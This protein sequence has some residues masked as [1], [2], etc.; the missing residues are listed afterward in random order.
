MENKLPPWE[1]YFIE[2]ACDQHNEFEYIDEEDVV[3]EVIHHRN[4]IWSF[5]E[6]QSDGE[7]LWEAEYY[8]FND[9]AYDINFVFEPWEIEQQNQFV[10]GLGNIKN[11]KR[12]ILLIY[13]DRRSFGPIATMGK[14]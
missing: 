11:E 9:P 5:R 4:L 13:D 1:D 12:K 10:N 6:M 2:W 14:I 8:E 7:K 3:N